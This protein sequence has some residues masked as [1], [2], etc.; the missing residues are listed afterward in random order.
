MLKP[1]RINKI[2]DI[3]EEKGSVNVKK[4][5]DY[6]DVTMMT[7]RRDL[8]EIEARNMINRTHGGAV[9]NISQEKK[10]E[11]P[12]LDRIDLMAS[13]K[14]R[15]AEKTSELL[16][17]DEVVFLG[18]GTTT[19]YVARAIAGREDISI[20]TNSLI[21]LNELA[22]NG[23]MPLIGIGG[24]L[25]R[26]EFSMIGHS[27]VEMIKDMHID[28]LIMGMRGVHPR[29]GLT[30]DNPQELITDKMLIEI[31]DQVIIVADHTKIGHVAASRTA[32][33][34]DADM[35]VTTRIASKE[36]VETIR[37]RGVEVYLA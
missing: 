24:L 10:N 28:K 5:S 9:F 32:M 3:L 2:I 29:F 27:S 34:E 1:E 14:A 23:R 33:I 18:S 6:F 30:S 35:I 26:S 13:E 7:I 16:N 15:I 4:L 36:M 12:S 8:D 20:V 37:D 21:I 31:S 22:L 11:L 19:L 17:S 25:R